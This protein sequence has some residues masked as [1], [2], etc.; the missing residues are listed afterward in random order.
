MRSA[1]AR[2][3]VQQPAPRRPCASPRRTVACCWLGRFV[4]DAAEAH[5]I[6][7]LEQ[8]GDD[9]AE[10]LKSGGSG[11]NLMAASWFAM[12]G[13]GIP[14]PGSLL[15]IYLHLGPRAYLRGYARPRR[16]PSIGVPR[17]GNGGL[18]CSRRRGEAALQKHA[19]VN[20]FGRC[21]FRLQ[22]LIRCTT[23]PPFPPTQRDRQEPD[24]R[25]P[26][27]RDRRGE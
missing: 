12:L 23:L 9:I 18:F 1:S 5:I 20:F 10:D 7:I 15:R 21:N 4:P 14:R 24:S 27:R 8:C 17:L 16:C 26:S 19:S 11:R 2:I 3:G 13:Q 6:S 22:L 25:Y